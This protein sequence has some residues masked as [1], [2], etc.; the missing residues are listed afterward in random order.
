MNRIGPDRIGRGFKPNWIEPV[1]LGEFEGAEPPH[2]LRGGAGGAAAP[3]RLLELAI[4]SE[5]ARDSERASEA[6]GR[7]KRGVRGGFSPPGVAGGLGGGSPPA[8]AS[9]I[10]ETGGPRGAQRAHL[11]GAHGVPKG[12]TREAHGVPKGPTGEP[13]SLKRTIFI[14]LILHQ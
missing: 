2:T 1:F 7:L 8:D 10:W 13:N 9:A 4:A 12:P 3:P 5:R 11:G 6:E 14:F